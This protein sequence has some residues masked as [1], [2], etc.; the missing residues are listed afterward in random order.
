MIRLVVGLLVV[1]ACFFYSPSKADETG[2]ILDNSNWTGNVTSCSG[3]S[4]WGGYSGGQN[5]SWNGSIFRWGYGG[6][7][8]HQQIALN[9]VFSDMG[10]NLLGY[11]YSWDVKN[12]NANTQFG[13]PQ[14][15]F[16]ISIKLYADDGSL[17]EVFNYDYSYPIPSHTNFSGTQY[18]SNEHWL[19]DLSNIQISATG[20]DAGYW[21]GWYGPEWTPRSLNLLYEVDACIAN[22]L[23]DTKCPGYAEA[24]YDQQC[25]YDPLYDQG[26]KGYAEAYFSQQ[27]SF[28]PLYDSTCPGYQEAYY[29]QQCS[30]DALYDMGCPGY[31]EAYYNYQC[32]LDA[33]YDSGCEG[34]ALAFEEQQCSFDP[35]YSPTCPG[36]AFPT[37]TSTETEPSTDTGEPSLEESMGITQEIVE[38]APEPTVVE[39]KIVEEAVAEEKKEEEIV[40]LK[41]VT[42]ESVKEE[43]KTEQKPKNERNKEAIASSLE[44]TASLLN[45]IIGNSMSSGMSESNLQ[46]SEGSLFGDGEQ[47]MSNL[48]SSGQDFNDFANT[49]TTDSQDSQNMNDSIAL[50]GSLG[51]GIPV[52]SNDN[53]KSEEKPEKQK[54][55]A[56]RMAEKIRKKNAEEQGGIFGKQESVLDSIAS[57]TD[58]NKYYDERLA[59]AGD[60]YGSGQIYDGNRLPDKGNSYYRMNSKSYGVMRDLIRSQY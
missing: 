5:P 57:A 20:R 53:N 36:Y 13:S 8:V 43:Q 40:E 16:N 46:G 60:W 12:W 17:L 25:S 35:Q 6:G 41:I 4:C 44:Q 24:Y 29:N 21:A 27:C 19:G 45:N 9:Q 11:R 54:S 52:P 50:G 37:V 30:L 26:C 33:L 48:S 39:E 28:D 3:S 31:A 59:D 7:S 22:P 42:E 2:N 38:N 15:P 34:Y 10:I 51:L 47:S 1:L 18:F 14:D 56:E 23:S 55:L 32:G 49:S 58:L